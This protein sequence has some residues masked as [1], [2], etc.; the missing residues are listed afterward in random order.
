MLS[1]LL[2]TAKQV[3]I[4][5]FYVACGFVL[6]KTKIL[7]SNASKVIAAL[8]TYFIGPIYTIL[9]LAE[10]ISLNNIINYLYVYL[11]GICFYFIDKTFYKR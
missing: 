2:I 1:M 5:V 7:S 4:L 8:L 3:S 9:N 11:S 10:G 6:V